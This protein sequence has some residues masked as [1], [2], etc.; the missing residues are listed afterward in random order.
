M[1]VD[2]NG[3]LILHVENDVTSAL[4][5]N[6]ES[7][8]IDVNSEGRYN[9]QLTEWRTNFGESVYSYM[10][11]QTNQYTIIADSDEEDIEFH[12]A[13]GEWSPA[14]NEFEPGNDVFYQRTLRNSSSTMNILCNEDGKLITFVD[15]TDELWYFEINYE[16]NKWWINWRQPKDNQTIYNNLVESAGGPVNG[17][18]V[19]QGEE[20]YSGI[21]ICDEAMLTIN[22]NNNVTSGYV[23]VWPT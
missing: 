4:V 2:S 6:V 21:L 7:G 9:T 19:N 8:I 14:V 20:Y 3:R 22:A 13:T 15:E 1:L 23:N 18:M 10:F 5:W 17:Q 11:N 12:D 16:E